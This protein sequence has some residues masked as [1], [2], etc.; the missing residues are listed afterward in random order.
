MLALLEKAEACL[1]YVEQEEDF[2]GG[3]SRPILPRFAIILTNGL[4]K[5]LMMVA[6]GFHQHNTVFVA[7]AVAAAATVAAGVEVFR[8]G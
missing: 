6:M 2:F 5:T 8:G 7:V 3:P 4:Q 1:G